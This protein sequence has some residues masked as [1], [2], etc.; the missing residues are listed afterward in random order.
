MLVASGTGFAPIKAMVEQARIKAAATRDAVST[1]ADDPLLGRAPPVDLYMTHSVADG[2][3][4]IP[5][6]TYVPVISDALPEDGLE[7]TGRLRPSR[8]DGRS[9]RHER[10][11]QVYA[12]GAP[13]VVESSRQDF[14]TRCGLRED[15]FFADAFHQPPRD[16]ARAVT[17]S[18]AER[19]L[20]AEVGGAHA[21]VAEHPVGAV[22]HRDQARV[23]HVAT[24]G[25]LQ[26]QP[27]VLL[28]QQHGRP[29]LVD[30]AN[31]LEDLSRP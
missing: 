16:L 4:E 29:A 11:T 19:R 14:I 18:T 1:A 20:L 28:D 22:G 8:G 10:R 12:C 21:R 15:A 5:G 17:G 23:H 26:R 31:D 27:G 30:L 3:T 24:V 2:M 7:R 6:F 13:I 9:S 25:R